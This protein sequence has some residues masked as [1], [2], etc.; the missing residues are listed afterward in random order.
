MK[1][2]NE[3][4][5]AIGAYVSSQAIL[6]YSIRVCPRQESGSIHI[7]VHG[8]AEAVRWLLFRVFVFLFC[9]FCALSFFAYLVT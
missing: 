2:R 7:N 4:R 6:L 9:A 1:L 8:E 5:R 3:M